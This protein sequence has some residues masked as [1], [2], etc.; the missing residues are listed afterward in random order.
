LQQPK[1]QQPNW[2]VEKIVADTDK[3]YARIVEKG[4]PNKIRLTAEK[5][6]E[7]RGWG[8]SLYLFKNNID[9][10]IEEL[11][12]FYVPKVMQPGPAFA[13]RVHPSITDSLF[14]MT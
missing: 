5:I 11:G 3:L 8:P 1:S 2:N 14:W 12:W 10:V 4:W 13:R 6:I 7:A 9:A